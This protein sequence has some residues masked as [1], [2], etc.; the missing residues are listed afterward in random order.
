MFCSLLFVAALEC[1]EPAR[2]VP[3]IPDPPKFNKEDLPSYGKQ[4]ATFADLYD[5]GWKDEVWQGS[6][7]LYDAQGDSVTR[8][9]MRMAL[10]NAEK[11]DKSLVKFLSPAEI[12][13]V[14]ALT[15]EHPE[16]T[17][18]NWLYLPASR[19]VRR[20]SGANKTASF[21]GSEFT[22]EDLSNLEIRKYDWK[23]LEEAKYVRDGQEVRCLK[24]EARPNY[25]DTGYSRLVVWYNAETWAQEKIEYFDKAQEHQKTLSGSGWQHI[26]KRFWRPQSLDMVNHQTRKRTKLAMEQRFL[27]LSFYKS[28]RTGKYRANL[29]DEAFTTRK[30]EKR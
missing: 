7:V 6:M 11:G 23:Y 19:R 3:P 10:E 8:R 5:R 20:I 9:T 30:L 2:S 17:D 4:I 12:K 16:S 22:Y 15:H 28:K 29:T 1:Q 18:D 26:H 25:D 13:D 27:N 14:A 24:V 21:Q